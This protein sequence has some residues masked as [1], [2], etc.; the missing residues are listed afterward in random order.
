MKKI[1]FGFWKPHIP[2]LLCDSDP[3]ASVLPQKALRQ[4]Q[5]M[6]SIQLKC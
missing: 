4:I 2:H 5:A 1:L 6:E 3:L